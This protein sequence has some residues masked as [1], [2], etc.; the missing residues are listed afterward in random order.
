[1]FKTGIRLVKLG[2][3]FTAE[4]IKRFGHFG[5]GGSEGSTRGFSQYEEELIHTY[6][7]LPIIARYEYSHKRLQPYIEFGLSPHLHLNSRRNIKTEYYS[8]SSIYNERDAIGFNKLQF[9]LVLSAGINYHFF[10]RL[11]AF[12]QPSYR[13]HLSSM[14]INADGTKAHFYSIGFEFGVRYSFSS[15][16]KSTKS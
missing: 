2:N 11:T 9:V 8:D 3:K 15:Y 1:M 13:H 16:F 10:K 14:R 5:T 4:N 7:E 6:I 12:G